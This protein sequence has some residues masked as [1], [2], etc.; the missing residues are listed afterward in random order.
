VP[1][2]AWKLGGSLKA[3]TERYGLG[4]KGTEVVNALGKRRLNFS[5][6]ELAR[7]GDYCIND[8]ELTYKLFTILV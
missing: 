8:V 5:D 3:L 6:E 7:Y 2:T 4:E 1:F